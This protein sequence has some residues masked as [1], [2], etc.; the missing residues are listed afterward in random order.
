LV[1]AVTSV[2]PGQLLGRSLAKV[3]GRVRACPVNVLGSVAGIVLF[4]ACAALHLSPFWW[5]LPAGVGLAYFLVTGPSPGASVLQGASRALL[6]ALIPLLAD[7]HTG[8]AAV[9]GEDG[10]EVAQRHSYWSPYYRVDF[11]G[12]PLHGIRVNLIGH[13]QMISRTAANSPAHAYALPHALH[14]DAGGRP[15]ENVLVIGA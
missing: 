15:F 3:P 7:W 5:F 14:R 8:T 11:D 1:R 2:G 4:A 10:A 6:L 12:A 9:H 13:Q